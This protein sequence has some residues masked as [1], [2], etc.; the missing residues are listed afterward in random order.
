VR[1]DAD[2][3]FHDFVVSRTPGLS[4]LARLLS[5]DSGAAED[6]VQVTLLR[7]WRSWPRVIGAT[8]P[9]AYVRRIMVNTAVSAWRRRW[10]VEVPTDAVPQGVTADGYQ[11]VDD[12]DHLVRT[13]RALPARQR[14]A[15]VL[16]YFA[17]LDD[18]AVADAL[19]CSIATVRSQISRALARLRVTATDPSTSPRLSKADRE[20]EPS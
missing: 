19:G 15:I 14:A 7:A 11:Q 6:L 20:R 3:H 4:R 9:D 13:V 2:G 8:D 12:R 17:D 18:A 10:R 5:S 16:R 1:V